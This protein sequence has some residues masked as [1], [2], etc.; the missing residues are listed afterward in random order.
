MGLALRADIVVE[1]AIVLEL[2]S[3]EKLNPVFS[4][5][6]FTYLK[7]MDKRLGFLVNFGTDNINY[8]Y[9]RVVNRF[10]NEEISKEIK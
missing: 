10:V 7:I 9:D 6:L 3:V 8:L 4:K 2:K 5:Q 1:N